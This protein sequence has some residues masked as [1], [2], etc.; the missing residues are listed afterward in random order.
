MWRVNLNEYVKVKLSDLGKE[1]YYH[2]YDETN[3]TIELH[4]EKPIKPT[5]P[6]V[7]EEGYTQFQIWQLMNLYGEYMTM[8]GERVFETL[9]VI[10]CGGEPVVETVS[11][12]KEAEN[13]HILTEEDVKVFYEAMERLHRAFMGAKESDGK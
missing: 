12:S 1:I 8:C 5:M 9:D 10:I 4:G 7:D 2:Q 13:N 6:K 3:R 11:D